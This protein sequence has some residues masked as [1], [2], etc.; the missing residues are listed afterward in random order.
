[1]Q[2]IARTDARHYPVCMATYAHF[3]KSYIVDANGCWRWQRTLD[4]DGYGRFK[5][6]DGTYPMAHKASV[7][8]HGGEVPVG[9]Q[10]D[11]LCRVRDCV[12]PSHLE[13][14]TP[15]VNVLRSNGLAAINAKKTVCKSGHLLDSANT[16]VTPNGR[17]NCRTCRAASVARYKKKVSGLA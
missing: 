17:R 14:V 12:N 1:M 11:H 7:L 6:P 2:T 15:G 8:L 5:M 16:Y 3:E 4:R 13:V 9:K 10:V